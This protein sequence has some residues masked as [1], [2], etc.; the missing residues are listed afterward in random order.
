MSY[1]FAQV[2]HI[3]ESA[4]KLPGYLRDAPKLRAIIDG[5][6]HAL[7]LAESDVFDLLDDGRSIDTS[8]GA[9]LDKIGEIVNEP[10]Q[11]GMSDNDYRDRLRIAVLV[12]ASTGTMDELLA[13]ATLMTDGDCVIR[14]PQADEYGGWVYIESDGANLAPWMG[15]YLRR[16]A[17]AG[18]HARLLSSQGSTP[19]F[20]FGG[21]AGLRQSG[22]SGGG[23]LFQ[24][25]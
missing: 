18:V 6:M 25:V 8:E 24:S 9:Q 2:N 17:P 10:R 12:I 16:A 4:A 11:A 15:L 3:N 20:R 23:K 21:V 14:E 5:I 7:N 1:N 19:V 22:Y 13:I